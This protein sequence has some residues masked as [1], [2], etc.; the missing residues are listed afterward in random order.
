MRNQ[1][2]AAPHQHQRQVLAPGLDAVDGVFDQAMDFS[3]R[4]IDGGGRQMQDA[5]AI[6][7][8]G[9]AGGNGDIG[10]GQDCSPEHQRTL[11][12]F[13]AHRLRPHPHWAIA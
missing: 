2:A 8:V 10:G 7:D 9:E 6:A 1:Q 12:Q 5:R 11:G 4:G 13:I 3:E